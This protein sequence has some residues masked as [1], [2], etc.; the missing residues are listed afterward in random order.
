MAWIM[1]FVA[2]A[3]GMML[4][5]IVVRAWKNRPEPVLADGITIPKG[6]EL[7]ALRVRARKETEL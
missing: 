2:L 7:D 5:T 6:S 4:V 3:F 1:P